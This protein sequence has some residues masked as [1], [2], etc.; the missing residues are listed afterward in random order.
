MAMNAWESI[1]V[2]SPVNEGHYD[3]DDL[4]YLNWNWPKQTWFQIRLNQ[5]REHQFAVSLKTMKRMGS[6]A[7]AQMLCS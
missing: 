1:F 5:L 4:P 7:E 3:E 2:Q 6:S